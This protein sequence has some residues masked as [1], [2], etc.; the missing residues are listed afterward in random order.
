MLCP[1]CHLQK[2]DVA[3]IRIEIID[4]KSREIIEVAYGEVLCIDCIKKRYKERA[5]I[6]VYV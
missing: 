6:R 2:E 1:D 4:K 3:R 5:R